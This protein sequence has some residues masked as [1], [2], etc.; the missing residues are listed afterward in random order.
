[1]SY[2]FLQNAA[3]SSSALPS[4]MGGEAGYVFGN[5]FKL[6]LLFDIHSSPMS[7]KTKGFVIANPSVTNPNMR[8][9]G[10]KNYTEIDFGLKL[11]LNLA[12]KSH[13][14]SIY[15]NSGIQTGTMQ[16]GAIGD[17]SAVTSSITIPIEVEGIIYRSGGFYD[18]G[19]AG[20]MSGYAGAN[21]AGAGGSSSFGADKFGFYYLAGVDLMMMN[22]T[23]LTPESNQ[24]KSDFTATYALKAGLGFSYKLSRR[25]R[26]FT[27]L[28][29]KYTALPQSSTATITTNADSPSFNDSFLPSMSSSVYF[30]KGS[31]LSVLLKIGVGF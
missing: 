26:F 19:G 24:A 22:Y 3:T 11:G 16:M 7:N 28:I 8:Y 10:A 25:A 5:V 29:A 17:V 18:A 6:G 15:I 27:R 1:M 21:G 14:K 9:A 4:G 31:A 23:F 12:S 30:P 2:L 13:S 20:L